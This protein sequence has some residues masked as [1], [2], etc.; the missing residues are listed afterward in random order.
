MAEFPTDYTT[1]VIPDWTDVVWSSDAVTNFNLTIASIALYTLTNS[2][3]DSL[4]EWVINLYYT[5]ARVTANS[6]VVALWNDKQDVSNISSDMVADAWSTT[7]YPSVLAA[8]NA[9]DGFSLPDATTTIKGKDRL[10]TNAEVKTWTLT[11]TIV[12]PDTFYKNTVNI[13]F[14][15]SDILRCSA[16]TEKTSTVANVYEKVKEIEVSEN[17]RKWG[18]IRIKFD[19]KAWVI[20][21]SDWDL[22]RNWVTLDSV[23]N[24]PSTSYVTYSWDFSFSEWDTIELWGKETVIV[25]NFRI[26]YDEVL[27]PK[28]C[29]VTLD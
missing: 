18:T 5:E 19:Y 20:N 13:G 7:K 12:V 14:I 2:D 17:Y 3:T 6:T 28:E 21:D 1:K 27:Y 9:I 4:P 23:S 26:Y 11:T 22:R 8:Q 29:S 15:A 16:D 10:A 24:I 25:R